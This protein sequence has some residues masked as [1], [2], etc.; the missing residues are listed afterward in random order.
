MVDKEK[1]KEILNQAVD[2]TYEVGSVVAEK[3]GQLYEVT[4]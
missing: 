3:T 2:K 4:S 1:A